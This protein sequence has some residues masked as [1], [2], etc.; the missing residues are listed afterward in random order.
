MKVWSEPLK[1]SVGSEEL[2]IPHRVWADAFKVSHLSV[3]EQT[4]YHCLYSRSTD[5]YLREA[6]VRALINLPITDWTSPYLFLAL[7]DY[8]IQVANVVVG[9][10]KLRDQLAK[11]AREN[12]ELYRLSTARAISFWD[13]NRYEG[14]RYEDYRD[15]PPYKFLKSLQVA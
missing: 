7:S 1:V 9:E 5:G 6:S 3:L 12:P 8:V 14:Y 11:F 10:E 13:L 4:M 15:F 2:D